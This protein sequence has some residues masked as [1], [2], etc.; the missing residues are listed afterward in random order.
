MRLLNSIYLLFIVTLAG[1]A[2]TSTLKDYYGSIEKYTQYRYLALAVEP[3]VQGK[4]DDAVR[5]NRVGSQIVYG[6]NKEA[7]RNSAL[8]QCSEKLAKPCVL[9]YEYDRND[10]SYRSNQ[11]N[12]IKVYENFIAESKMKKCDGYGFKRGTTPF[13]QCI[14]QIEQ[15]QAMQDSMDLSIQIQQ[16][17]IAR[18]TQQEYFRKAQCHFSG[19]MDC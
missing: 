6:N 12:N 15:Q 4:T 8:K 13:A 11:T 2:S 3:I 18:Q 16:N 19:R 7:V 9:A 10:N 14:Q 5:L 17:E 1:C